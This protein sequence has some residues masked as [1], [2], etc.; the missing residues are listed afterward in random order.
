MAK[1]ITVVEIAAELNKGEEL[2]K[3]P[4]GVE[5]MTLNWK[6]EELSSVFAAVESLK[7]DSDHVI[8]DGGAPI[9][10]MVAVAHAAHPT[11]FSLNYPQGG[12]TLPV[13]GYQAK[14]GVK[15]EFSGFSLQMEGNEIEFKMEG[16]LDVP[17]VLAEMQASGLPMV[18]HGEPVHLGGRAPAAIYAAVADAVAHLVPAVTVFQPGVGRVVAIS[19]STEYPLGS[20]LAD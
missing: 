18:K 19:H 14:A 16:A 4:N 17:K 10:F 8:L 1:V 13:S 20:V 6:P 7:G 3:L 12:T 9:W 2:V 11:A 15:G 5:R